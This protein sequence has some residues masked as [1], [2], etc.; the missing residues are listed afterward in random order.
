MLFAVVHCSDGLSDILVRE[1][2]VG[3]R[4]GSHL[5]V[6]LAENVIEVGGVGKHRSRVKVR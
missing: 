5:N 4:R 2:V 1:E 6:T 3:G